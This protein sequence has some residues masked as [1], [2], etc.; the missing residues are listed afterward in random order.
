MLFVI[1]VMIVSRVHSFAVNSLRPKGLNVGLNVERDIIGCDA[2]KCIIH[3]TRTSKGPHRGLVIAHATLPNL[4]KLIGLTAQKIGDLGSLLALFGLTALWMESGLDAAQLSSQY[5]PKLLHI[6][7]KLGLVYGRAVATS[8]NYNRIY[9][10]LLGSWFQLSGC[11]VRLPPLSYYA[12]GAR[13]K[14]VVHFIGGFLLGSHSAV[15][16]NDLLE[17]LADAGHIIVVTPIPWFNTNHELVASEAAERFALCLKEHIEPILESMGGKQDIPVIGFSHSLGCKLTA[18]IDSAPAAG[19]PD[20]VRSCEHD[21]ETTGSLD[22]CPRLPIPVSPAPSP[23]ASWSKKRAN[24]FVSFN[25]MPIREDWLCLPLTPSPQQTWD[26][27]R[28]GYRVAESIIIKFSSDKLDQSDRLLSELLEAGAGAVGGFSTIAGR[29][30]LRVTKQVVE[31]DH[32]APCGRDSRVFANLLD[33]LNS[34]S[35][36]GAPITRH[37][38]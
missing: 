26:R 6:I 27:I 29:T 14:S 15:S 13:P 10:S 9:D 36:S 12:T 31:G 16:Y 21:P 20:N 37:A 25:N 2:E 34:V 5:A 1:L 22:G 32:L 30:G 3:D 19:T 8:H 18:L 11:S 33:L 38:V 7:N 35:G 23:R 24:I 4:A 17:V 28:S